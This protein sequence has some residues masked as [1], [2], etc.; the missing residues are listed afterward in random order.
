MNQFIAKIHHHIN[1]HILSIKVY[2]YI[3]TKA[4][5]SKLRSV[6]LSIPMKK[7]F[8][9]ILLSFS[10]TA[11]TPEMI[12]STPEP[13]PVATKV[14]QPQSFEFTATQDSITAYE[15]LET[16]AT[17]EAQQYDFG[18]FVT[19]IN[20]V[21]PPEGSFWALYLN[22]EKAQAGASDLILKTGDV[23]SWRVEPIQ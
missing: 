16:S 12:K 7:I 1:D 18:A 19:S 5:P 3:D 22:N 4:L 11:C 13:T 17:V 20:G 10:V 15:L 23:V 2:Y 9:F 14:A 8:L 6:Y 21:T